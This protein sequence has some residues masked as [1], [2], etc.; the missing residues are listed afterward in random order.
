LA[1]EIRKMLYGEHDPY[2]NVDLLDY[3]KFAWETED[4]K[5]TFFSI[6]DEFKPKTILEIGSWC[7]ASAAWM[8]DA[9][10]KANI[11]DVEIVCLDTWLGSPE[12][13][14]GVSDFKFVNGRPD[15]YRQFLTNIIIN[16]KTETITPFSIDSHSGMTW[17]KEHGVLFDMIYVDGAH[18][19]KAVVNDILDAVDILKDGGIILGDDFQH[20]PV[21]DAFMRVL[22]SINLRDLGKKVLWIK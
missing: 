20:P 2:A 12:H 7:G 10:I 13:W 14:G 1:K 6:I 21:Q 15:L 16:K 17:L 22:G 5:D 9:T 19:Y 3:D 8:H 11:S 18:D 4:S